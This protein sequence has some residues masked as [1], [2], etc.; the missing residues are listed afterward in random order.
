[1]CACGHTCVLTDETR[2][3]VSNECTQALGPADC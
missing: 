2:H 1:V 3:A